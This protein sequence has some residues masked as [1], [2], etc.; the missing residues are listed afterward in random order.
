MSINYRAESRLVPS[1]WQALIQS[2]AV[3]HF[4]GANLKSEMYS[5][6]TYICWTPF[7]PRCP[8]LNYPGARG[9]HQ[10]LCKQ[11]EL[12]PTPICFWKRSICYPHIEQCLP[13]KSVV[14]PFVSDNEIITLTFTGT[15]QYNATAFQGTTSDPNFSHE[16]H[17]P[18]IC[19]T[20]HVVMTMVL[21]MIYF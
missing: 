13:W 14:R 20:L 7:S 9:R 5:F 15:H 18:I 10:L 11:I 4:L 8:P 16:N 21:V 3:S 6:L 12:L 17:C 1:Q 19:H 2:N